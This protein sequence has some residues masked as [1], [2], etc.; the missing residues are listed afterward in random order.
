MAHQSL[1][2]L[3]YLKTKTKHLNKNHLIKKALTTSMLAALNND[4]SMLLSM[5]P[6]WATLHIGD[7]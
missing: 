4:M 7:T 1:F 2:V 6:M 3:L 5:L